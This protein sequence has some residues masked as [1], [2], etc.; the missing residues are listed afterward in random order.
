MSEMMI[1]AWDLFFDAPAEEEVATPPDGI[2]TFQ[3]KVAK[4]FADTGKVSLLLRTAAGEQMWKKL[5]LSDPDKRKQNR[6]WVQVL[7]DSPPKESIAETDWSVCE[8]LKLSANVGRFTPEGGDREIV[9]VNQPA[10]I[11]AVETATKKPPR[12]T[13]TAKIDAETKAG[14][15]DIP[16]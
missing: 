1:K 16:F 14:K 7:F 11:A 15:A 10:K 12:A 8:G 3:I 13:R 4:Y 6:Q 5:Y 2:H 9:F